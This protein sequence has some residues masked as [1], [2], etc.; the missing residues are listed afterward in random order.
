M[1]ILVD[2]EIR[3]EVAEG[4]LVI[5][6]YEPSLVQPNSYDVRLANRFSWHEPGVGD[7][8][9]IDPYKAESVLDGLVQ[10]VDEQI[11][12]QPQQFILEP[13][14]SASRFQAISSGN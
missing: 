2:F 10:L 1:S 8:K 5:E 4:K 7:D 11:V 12:I 3:K 14:S 9:I 6:P 13:L